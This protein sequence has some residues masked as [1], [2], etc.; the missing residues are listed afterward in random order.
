MIRI[1]TATRGDKKECKTYQSHVKF[2]DQPGIEFKFIENNT[3]PLA[4]VYN[5][6]LSIISDTDVDYV[7]FVHDDVIFRTPAIQ[8]IL[9]E[10][11]YDISGVAGTA[12]IEVKE[13]ALWHLMSTR[14]K[15]AGAVAHPISESQYYVTSFGPMP[16]RVLVVDGVVIAVKVS[17][18]DENL[19]FDEENPGHW[20]HYD[21][22]FCL[23]GNKHRKTI[24]V[25]DIPIIHSSPGLSSLDDTAFKL[26][27]KWFIN[28]WR[29]SNK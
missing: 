21:L 13:P 20:H 6:E 12:S 16:S 19:R 25:V 22:D 2:W 5:E 7:I 18:I 26:S 10:Q 15:Y 23:T 14:D 3:R 1:V 11:Q 27:Q 28:K 8:A 24:G 29:S 17:A 9:D 4:E